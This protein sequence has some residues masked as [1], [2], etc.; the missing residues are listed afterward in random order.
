MYMLH[1][2]SVFVFTKHWSSILCILLWYMCDLL[3][4]WSERLLL[5]VA[6][7]FWDLFSLFTLFSLL[8]YIRPDND[9][10]FILS[11]CSLSGRSL[12]SL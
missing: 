4:Y 6:M 1:F 12:L 7:F 10:G 11:L 5:Q 3:I 2:D 8:T 9:V